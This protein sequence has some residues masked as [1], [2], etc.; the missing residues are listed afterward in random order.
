MLAR[1]RPEETSSL[2]CERLPDDVSPS[3]EKRSRSH[4]KVKQVGSWPGTDKQNSLPSSKLDLVEDVE[5]RAILNIPVNM[6]KS[7][8][9]STPGGLKSSGSFL[10]VLDPK[11]GTG[12]F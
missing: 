3:C 9:H 7:E 12:G 8:R 11:E 4:G 2:S 1:R 10:R 6:A 5:I